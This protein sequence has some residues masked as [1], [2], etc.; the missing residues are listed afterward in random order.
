[1]SRVDEVA[2]EFPRAWPVAA[3][4]HPRATI[5]L[6]CGHVTPTPYHRPGQRHPLPQRTGCQDSDVEDAIVG[7]GLGQQPH[8]TLQSPR[9]ARRTGTGEFYRGVVSDVVSPWDS[10]PLARE[11]R[12][13]VPRGTHRVTSL[14][15]DRSTDQDSIMNEDA[16]RDDR[17]ELHNT[18]IDEE[19]AEVGACAQVHLPTGRT[20]ILEHHHEGS[21][22]FVPRDELEESLTQHRTGSEE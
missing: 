19:A 16:H 17:Q 8:A 14:S 5:S 2:V 3:H 11:R 13:A 12:L 9:S 4:L 20:C 15:G 1:M 7:L 6:H 22:N 10:R 21:C 18:S